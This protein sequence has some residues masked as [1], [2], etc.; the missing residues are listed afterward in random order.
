MYCF[1]E[2]LHCV[3]DI[4]EKEAS[5]REHFGFYIHLL[6]DPKAEKQKA[7]CERSIKA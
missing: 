3:V 7:L 5:D 6:I 2:R 1:K 4:L